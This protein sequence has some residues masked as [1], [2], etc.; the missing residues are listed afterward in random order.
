VS[1][2][3]GD[4]SITLTPARGLS[5]EV[6]TEFD[7]WAEGAATIR[8]DMEP[9]AADWRNRVEPA[10]TFA[11]RREVEALLAA[12]LAKGGTTEN[13]LVITP[14]DEFSSP[15]RIDAEWCAHKAADLL[16]DLALVGARI[17]AHVKAI[18]PGHTV[19]CDLARRLLAIRTSGAIGQMEQCV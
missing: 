10:R 11:F 4:S 18:R 2:H 13:A 9:D 7:D 17:Q 14:P 12:G 1:I 3:A 8:L 19:N 16:G 5:L 15:L 6:S